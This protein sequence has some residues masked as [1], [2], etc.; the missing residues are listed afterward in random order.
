M[1]ELLVKVQ[2]LKCYGKVLQKLVPEEY[3]YVFICHSGS[4]NAVL[5][6]YSAKTALA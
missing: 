6:H 4:L 3:F 2:M 5:V 1:V